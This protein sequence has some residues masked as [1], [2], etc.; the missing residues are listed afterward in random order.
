MG[1]T[2]LPIK[3]KLKIPSMEAFASFTWPAMLI[4]VTGYELKMPLAPASITS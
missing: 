4:S 3:Y 2:P 1:E